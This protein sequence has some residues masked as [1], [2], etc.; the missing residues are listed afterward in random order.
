[1]ATL[2]NLRGLRRLLVRA[3][4]FYYTR[5]FDMDIHPSVEF[6]L[7]ANFDRT[8]PRGVHVGEC[9]YVAFGAVILAHDRTRGLYLHT[10]VG[11]NCFVGA[12][13]IIMPGVVVG[14]HCVIGAGSVV[15]KDVAARTAVAGNP[16][17]VITNDIDVGAYGRFANADSVT[18]A[19]KDSGGL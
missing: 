7:S 9:T 14:D 2:H 8:F 3:K 11:R 19:L 17:R 12:H 16:A 13:S 10:R 6:S 1:M 5:V 4:W 18:R 15:T